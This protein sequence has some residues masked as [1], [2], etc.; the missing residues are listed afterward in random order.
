MYPLGRNVGCRGCVN[1]KCQVRKNIKVTDTF[2]SFT[3]K[4]AR[5]LTINLAALISTWS[6]SSAAEHAVSNIWVR[7][8]NSWGGWYGKC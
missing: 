6:T 1:G 3:T 7:S 2:N 5:K 4:K 8:K